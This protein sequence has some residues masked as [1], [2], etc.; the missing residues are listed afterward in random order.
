MSNGTTATTSAK[1]IVTSGPT[2]SDPTPQSEIKTR[3]GPGGKTLS[4]IDA[5][6]VMER[7]DSV[8]GP[9]RWQDR[10]EDRADGSVRCGIGIYDPSINEWVWKWDVGDP[11]DIEATKGAHSDA[12]KRAGVKWGIGRDL[13]G[14]H[15]QAPQKPLERPRTPAAP[16]PA[17]RTSDEPPWPVETLDGGPLQAALEVFGA[18]VLPDESTCPDHGFEWK[19]NSRGYYCS[20]KTKGAW[21]AR[22]PS[23]AWQ[24]R[25][26]TAA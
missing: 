25:H 8:V 22:S 14:D 9:S 12:F 2:L 26:E 3:Q 4:Y 15:P 23:K 19:T 1:V 16:V 24:A 5:R 7:L 18:D 13:Y 6:F 10:F 20:G 11:S 17:P 21:C